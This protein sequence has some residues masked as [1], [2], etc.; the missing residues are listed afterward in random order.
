MERGLTKIEQ[1][2]L[3]IYVA[4]E[5]AVTKA[6]IASPESAGH[7]PTSRQLMETSFKR[8]Y[9]FFDVSKEFNRTYE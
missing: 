5:S 1:V 3:A 9:I 6:L 4:G 7:A 2:A 8:A